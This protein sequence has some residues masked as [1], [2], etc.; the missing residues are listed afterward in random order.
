[1]GHP[2]YQLTHLLREIAGSWRSAGL[3]IIVLSYAGNTSAQELKEVLTSWAAFMRSEGVPAEGFCITK[4]RRGPYGK[5]AFM[6]VH[7]C[8]IL[9]D[10]DKKTGREVYQTG[11]KF[12][13]ARPNSLDWAYELQQ[14]AAVTQGIYVRQHHCARVLGPGEWHNNR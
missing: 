2:T 8:H 13:R 3:Q 1:M 7:R 14:Y 9:V 6:G 10:D 5:A 12:I 11:A 4:D